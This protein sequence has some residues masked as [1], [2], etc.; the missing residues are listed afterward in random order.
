SQN[1]SPDWNCIRHK[2]KRIT[3]AIPF[4]VM[5]PHDWHDRIRKVNLL[6]NLRPDDRMNLH[7]LE[8]FRRQL[9]RLG[10]DVLRYRKFSYVMKYG[11]GLQVLLL[12]LTQTEF[13]GDFHGVN[14]Y[15]LQMFA[16]SCVFG[17]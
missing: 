2:P 8:F 6:Q 7:L 11:R 1:S 12:V 9:S 16:G 13:L 17:F 3:A 14:A 5:S 10:D 15:P 4:F